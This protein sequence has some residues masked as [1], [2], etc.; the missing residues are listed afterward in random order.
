[1]LISINKLMK[2][3]RSIQKPSALIRIARPSVD[4]REI[5]AITGVL[6]S[7]RLVQGDA[8]ANFEEA[9][10]RR[11]QL[12]HAI[13]VNSG[14]SALELAYKLAGISPGDTVLVPSFTFC[15][16][17]NAAEIL[18]ANVRFC[19]VDLET[20][21][22]SNA[23]LEPALTKNTSAVCVVHQFG[24]MADMTS[25]SRLLGKRTLIEDAACAIGATFKGKPIGHFGTCAILSFHPRKA[26]TTGEGG[27][28]L[29]NHKLLADQA[30]ALRSHGIGSGVLRFAPLFADEHAP[31]HNMRMTELQAAIG[32]IQLSKLDLI[33]K[34]RRRIARW[35]HDELSH[36]QEIQL[37]TEPTDR[38]HTYQSYVCLI[39]K[40]SK[41]TGAH[42][43]KALAQAGIESRPGAHAIH[44]LSYYRKK[45]HIQPSA[46]PNSLFA[47]QNSFALPIYPTL[48]EAEVD[49][50]VTIVK[51]IFSI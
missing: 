4:R 28:I 33:L 2:R 43:I 13:A 14:T 49:R 34:R 29:T 47:M 16:T 25:I 45:Y 11:C 23:T 10:A 6:K 30:R 19:D 12:R 37:P 36:L 42:I 5:D 35:Y 39:R 22:A 27:M 9:V 24:L 40:N 3:R 46:L 51:K 8:V 26:I 44:T 32:N 15:A 31:G 41:R 17:A 20:F 38:L 1:M 7:G 18:G 50:I 21:N 48:K